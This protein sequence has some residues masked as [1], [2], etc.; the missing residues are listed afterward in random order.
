M[1]DNKL[2]LRGSLIEKKLKPKFSEL[3]LKHPNKIKEYRGF[4]TMHGFIF[5]MLKY[6][7]ITINGSIISINNSILIPVTVSCT[8]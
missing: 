7:R 4:G 1:I 6:V 3:A 5:K 2:Y 8:R